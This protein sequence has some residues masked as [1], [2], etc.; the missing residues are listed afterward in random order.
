MTA[1]CGGSSTTERLGPVRWIAAKRLLTLLRCLDLLVIVINLLRLCC[2]CS[3]H[4]F[5]F[6][7]KQGNGELQNLFARAAIQ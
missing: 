5:L 7:G 2:M 6:E 4:Y 3:I 1:A